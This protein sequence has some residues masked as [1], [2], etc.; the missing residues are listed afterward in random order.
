[1]TPW[2]MMSANRQRLASF[3]D[4]TVVLIQTDDTAKAGKVRL[5]ASSNLVVPLS[6]ALAG[7]MSASEAFMNST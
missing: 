1:M 2:L 5:V 7:P 3:P 6:P 4:V